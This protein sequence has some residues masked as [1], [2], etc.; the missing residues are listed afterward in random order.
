MVEKTLECF[1]IT[2]STITETSSEQYDFAIE[3][4]VGKKHVATIAKVN[5]ASLK[6]CDVSQDVYTATLFNTSI[7]LYD[8]KE[9][10]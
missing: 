6:K 4:H 10:M 8:P 9:L 3:Y 2:S 1:S 7:F 5:K